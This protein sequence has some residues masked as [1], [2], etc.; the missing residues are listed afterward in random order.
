MVVRV[1]ERKSFEGTVTPSALNVETT[2]VEIPAETEYYFVE[3]YLDLSELASGD[4]VEVR[5]Y[6]D[7]KRFETGSYSGSQTNPILHFPTKKTKK[8]YK[9]TITQTSGTIRSFAYDFSQ[10]LT[11]V[12]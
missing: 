1:K 11:E 5:E 4:T 12:V 7:G 6:I 9:V 3:G 10:F 8:A 2:V